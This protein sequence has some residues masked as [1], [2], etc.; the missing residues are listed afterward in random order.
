M[1]Y[2]SFIRIVLK[3]S[4]HPVFSY[5][6]AWGCF[7]KNSDTVRG[8]IT[9]LQ[10]RCFPVDSIYNNRSH[11][12]HS[13]CETKQNIF[14]YTTMLYRV[15]DLLRFS[16]VDGSRT[17]V[18]KPIPCPSTIIVIQFCDCSPFPLPDGGRRP[19]G[20]SSF[21]VRPWGQSLAHV[22][23]YIVDAWVLMCRCTKSDS[24]P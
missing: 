19:S 11:N 3:I 2:S 14:L 22:V 24:C 18:Q 6:Q 13:L 7:Y 8:V 9:Y 1:V 15:F 12:Y 20:F 21:M 5:R 16:G 4:K 10:Y 17:R 23:S